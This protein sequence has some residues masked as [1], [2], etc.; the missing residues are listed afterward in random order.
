MKIKSA[1]KY[2]LGM[3]VLPALFSGTVLAHETYA[4]HDH[5]STA[6]KPEA[7]G[8]DDSGEVVR[9]ATGLCWRTGYWTPAMAIH[10]CDPDL[11]KKPEKVVVAPPAPEPE[12]VPV[13]PP[14]KITFSADALFDFD[15][16]KLK[17]NGVQALD[18]FANRL[19]NI[20]YD[21]IIAVGYADRIGSDEYNKALSVRRAESVKEYLV[22]NR[23]IDPNRVFTDGKGEAN[24]VTGDS[25]KGDRR[26]KALIDCLEPDRRVEIEVA[27]T[28]SR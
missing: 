26:T 8:V 7:Y 22:S 18:D 23:G 25:C 14:E 20:Q 3:I 5:D 19:R 13:T 6:L 1:K 24:P 28:R 17:P 12:P 21:L 16:A 11:I 4:D 2:L 9:N 10:E 15:S 27:G